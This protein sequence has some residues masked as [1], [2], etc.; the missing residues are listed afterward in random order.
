MTGASCGG[1]GGEITGC[2]TC[3]DAA[4]W[5]RVVGV[6]ASGATARCVDADGRHESVAVELVGAVAPNDALLVH[7]GAAIHREPA[8]TAPVWGGG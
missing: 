8:A 1:Q 7:A 3:G 4:V 5:V 2:I 6:D